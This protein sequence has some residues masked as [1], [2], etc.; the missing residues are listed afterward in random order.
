MHKT[1]DMQKRE[2]EMLLARAT[3]P[4]KEF[5]EIR[6]ESH[7]LVLYEVV[8]SEILN[9][10]GKPIHTVKRVDTLY[11]DSIKGRATFLKGLITMNAIGAMLNKKFQAKMSKQ[12]IDAA[13]NKR[14]ID[15]GQKDS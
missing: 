1:I 7:S 5:F 4:M 14:K 6:D 13:N 8:D 9:A 10:E 3:G 11:E 15:A 12:A 2:L